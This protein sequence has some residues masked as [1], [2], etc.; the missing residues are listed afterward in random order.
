MHWTATD[1]ATRAKALLQ[2]LMKKN[3]TMEEKFN[4]QNDRIYARSCQEAAENTGKE[5]IIQ[6]R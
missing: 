5:V 6:T 3:F 4:R 1:N 2:R